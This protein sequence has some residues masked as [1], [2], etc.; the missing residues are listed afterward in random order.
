MILNNK[1]MIING[2]KSNAK[3]SFKTFRKTKKHINRQVARHSMANRWQ[4]LATIFALFLLGCAQQS[5]SQ[6][7]IET[8]QGEVPIT[9]EIAD[10]PDERQVGLMYRQTLGEDEGMWFVFD[11]EQPYSFWMKNTLIPLDIVYVD[12]N[13]QIIDI[14]RADPCLEDICK[15]YTP[16]AA[17]TYVLEV[18]Q[19]FTAR[20]G[21]QIGNKVKVG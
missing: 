10:S 21:V 3:N 15:T 14:I 18:N 5:A 6:L 4:I 13:M 19:N 8:R 11:E 16:Q 9:I 1:L 7:T 12:S 17:A 2:I 20:A